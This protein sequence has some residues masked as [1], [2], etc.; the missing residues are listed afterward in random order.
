MHIV[1]HVSC[2]N[3]LPKTLCQRFSSN[4]IRTSNRSILYVFGHSDVGFATGVADDQRHHYSNAQYT[5]WRNQEQPQLRQV[6]QWVI[7]KLLPTR[8]LKWCSTFHFLNSDLLSYGG[9]L[10]H[11]LLWVSQ[12]SVNATSSKSKTGTYLIWMGELNFSE[13]EQ[14]KLFCKLLKRRFVSYCFCLTPFWSQK[15]HRTD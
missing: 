11:D 14:K 7:F 13:N 8:Q 4:K 9:S 6:K 5:K 2:L 1:F 12:N 3:N 10:D 15:N